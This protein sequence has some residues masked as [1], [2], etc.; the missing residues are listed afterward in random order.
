MSTRY[1]TVQ[2]DAERLAGDLPMP[3]PYALCK[4]IADSLR[5]LL[6]KIV[7]DGD[8]P[9]GTDLALSTHHY[10]NAG[11]EPARRILTLSVVSYT[12]ADAEMVA[13]G[14]VTLFRTVAASAP[15]GVTVIAT[16]DPPPPTTVDP[17]PEPQPTETAP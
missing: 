11:A 3:E 6:A 1:L 7:A 15:P 17:T 14:L 16:L 13:A 12:D 10:T 9:T 4:L 2:L 5:Q 8:V